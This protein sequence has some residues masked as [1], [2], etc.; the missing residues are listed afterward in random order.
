MG[1]MKLGEKCDPR[2]KSRGYWGLGVLSGRYRKI[3]KASEGYEIMIS[4]SMVYTPLR[5]SLVIMFDVM[6][7]MKLL[8]KQVHI[9]ELVTT[10]P[11][12]FHLIFHL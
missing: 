2:T 8:P 12:C 5:T 6:T 7:T 11:F 10:F 9:V 3:L 4:I 1:I